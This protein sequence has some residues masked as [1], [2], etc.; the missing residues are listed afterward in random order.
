[1][2]ENGLLEEDI[3]QYKSI[4]KQKP[5]SQHSEVIATEI[6]KAKFENGRSQRNDSRHGGKAPKG[7]GV[8]KKTKQRPR[9][10][11][12]QT[13]LKPG[14][15][16]GDQ[17]SQESLSTTSKKERKICKKQ[18]TTK[19]RPVF[20][21]YCPSCQMPFSLLLI[22]TPQWH[23]TECLDV[24]GTAEK[25]TVSM[26]SKGSSILYLKTGYVSL[27]SA[28]NIFSSCNSVSK[29]TLID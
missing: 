24:S 26:G 4:R 9:Q 25:G 13:P 11:D 19:P 20:D 22:Q 7:K 8:P 2:S 12:S 10:R 28:N 15:S 18:N 1:M 6:Q 17:S 3:W 27:R 14:V 5:T 16:S 29:K 21:G 23:V